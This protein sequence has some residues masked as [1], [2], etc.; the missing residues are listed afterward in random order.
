MESEVELISMKD[1]QKSLTTSVTDVFDHDAGD[2]NESN[3]SFESTDNPFIVIASKCNQSTLIYALDMLLTISE[4]DYETKRIWK[5]AVPYIGQAFLQGTIQVV[6][7]ALIGTFVGTNAVTAYVTVELFV[8]LTAGFFKGIPKSLGLL[9]PQSE[10]MKNYTLTGQ[11][12]QLSLVI[13]FVC[14]IPTMIACIC[15]VDTLLLWLGLSN[16]IV[17]LGKDFTK[18]FV[19]RETFN[20][21][22]QNL[23]AFLDIVGHEVYSTAFLTV[24]EVIATSS[25]AVAVIWIKPNLM[26]TAYIDAFISIIF[27][28]FNIGILR[29]KG[30]L[31]RYYSGLLYSNAF[32]VCQYVS[33]SFYMEP[34]TIHSEHSS[35]PSVIVYGIHNLVQLSSGIWRMANIDYFC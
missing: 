29:H 32:Q 28:F 4:W 17:M 3:A 5:L 13:F 35:P 20:G 10:G 27:L 25:I 26:L 16:E 7:V 2:S 19:V 9:G 15:F 14:T 30:W 12:L 6:K 24:K 21:L 31:R 33:I 22:D 23:H 1:D 18:L 8:G 34:L 11:Y